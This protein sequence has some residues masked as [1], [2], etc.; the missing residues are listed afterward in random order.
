MDWRGE[1]KQAHE[2]PEVRVRF[3]RD[4]LRGLAG[5]QDGGVQEN[6]EEGLEQLPEF[7]AALQADAL[8]GDV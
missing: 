4:Q 5:L 7:E 3:V 1:D 8:P 2:G 6:D